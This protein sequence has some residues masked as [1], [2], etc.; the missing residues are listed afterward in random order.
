MIDIDYLMML[1]EKSNGSL[2]SFDTAIHYYVKND[3]IT[4][5]VNKDSRDT[6]RVWIGDDCTPIRKEHHPMT[7]KFVQDQ[8]LQLKMR[9]M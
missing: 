3:R 6:I 1:T 8:L 7:H 5:T 2:E 4:I 9:N